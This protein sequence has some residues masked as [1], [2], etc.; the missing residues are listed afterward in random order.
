M[1]DLLTTALELHQSGQL[2]PAAQLHPKF[3]FQ[4]R[5]NASALHL[6]G[7]L[8]DQQGQHARTGDMIGRAV[9][10]S[11]PLNRRGLERRKQNEVPLSDLFDRLP[12]D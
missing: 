9:A 1:N 8:P 2:E 12:L 7:V 5:D 10:S 11:Q 3:L 6:L 4:E